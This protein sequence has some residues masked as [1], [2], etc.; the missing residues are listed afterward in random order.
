MFCDAL[1]HG[2]RKCV[3][4]HNISTTYNE[5]IDFSSG[6]LGVHG[7]IFL[8]WSAQFQEFPPTTQ[9]LMFTVVGATIFQALLDETNSGLCLYA[10]CARI[11]AAWRERGI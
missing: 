5:I 11:S 2:S 3:D 1:P 4:A 6:I 8:T 10:C 9:S 7:E